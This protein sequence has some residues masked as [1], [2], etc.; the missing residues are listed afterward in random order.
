MG[1]ANPEDMSYISCMTRLRFAIRGILLVCVFSGTTSIFSQNRPNIVLMIADDVSWNDLGCYGHPTVQT[2]NINYLAENGIRFT[3]AY[4]TTSS[5]SP[6][7]C[8]LITGRY[9]HNTGAAE[10]HTPLPGQQVPFTRLL[11]NAGYYTGH[12]GKWHMGPAPV[13]S[14]DR[15][16]A[17]RETSLDNGNGGEGNWIK[18]LQ[19]RPRQK[20]FF[21]WFAAHDA[22][23]IWHADTFHMGHSYEDAIIPPYLVDSPGTRQDLA[24]Y[25]NEI[26]RF[27]YYVG[28]VWEELRRQGVADNTVFIIMADNGRPF[29]RC[30]TRLYDSGIK[31]PL[32]ICWPAG[33]RDRGAVSPSLVSAIDIGPTILDLAGVRQGNSFQ[34]RSFGAVLRNPQQPFRRFVFAEHNWHDHEAH[35]RMVRDGHFMYIRNARPNQSNPGPADSNR[36]PSHQDL[37]MLRDAGTLS[38]AQ[39]DI[40]LYPR[41]AEELYDCVND[42]E[43]LV[44]L[45]SVPKYQPILNQLREVMNTWQ[46]ETGDTTPDQL[47]PDWFDRETGDAMDIERIRGEMP[48]AAMEAERIR[49]A[50]PGF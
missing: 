32:V 27:D 8:S 33:I 29:P 37:Q 42:P 15:A 17:T 50:G 25:Y 43:Q 47:T 14:F 20:P 31:T 41:P 45:A 48:G 13:S 4:L 24:S 7:R 18:W 35:E 19:E 23:R 26:T 46:Q 28:K 44:N 16:T 10:L 40:F 30:K 12:A 36:S 38:P 22:H 5:C 21:F 39:A 6:S 49:E 3:Q 2:P 11:K 9:P 1:F 34:G